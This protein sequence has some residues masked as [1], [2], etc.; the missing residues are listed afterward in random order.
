[1]ARPTLRVTHLVTALDGANAP[2]VPPDQTVPAAAV[3]VGDVP[4]LLE[5][6][7]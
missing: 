4:V 7:N 3:P 1:M 2:I 5:G 6:V